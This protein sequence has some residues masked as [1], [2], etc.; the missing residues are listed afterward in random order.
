MAQNYELNLRD[1]LRIVRK[2]YRVILAVMLLCGAA[3]FVLTPRE[4]SRYEANATVKITHQSSVASLFVDAVTWSW[5]D[6]LAT[7]SRIIGSLPMALEVGQEMGLFAEELTAADLARSEV[8]SAKVAA[9]N[10]LYEAEP[11]TGTSLIRITA[12]TPDPEESIRLCNVVVDTYHDPAGQGFFRIAIR[13]NE[14]SSR[15]RALPKDIIFVVDASNP[16]SPEIV[17]NAD[18]PGRANSVAVSGSHAYVADFDQGGLQVIDVSDPAAP[19]ITGSVDTP[20]YATGVAV[21]RMHGCLQW[22]VD[23]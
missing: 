18:T 12:R 3:T 20:S 14:Q 19:T 5:G 6:D 4:G 15:L 21:P 8:L 13:P 2:R 23:L 1:Y 7:Q 9:F 10:A 17:G 11:V 16:F 22:C